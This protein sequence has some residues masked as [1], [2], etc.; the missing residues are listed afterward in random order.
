MI[1]VKI[2]DDG[3][4]MSP[5]EL[6]H[7]TEPFYTTKPAGTGIGLAI[8]K[9]YIEEIGGTITISSEKN[10]Y[11]CV[12]IRLPKRIENEGDRH[13]AERSDH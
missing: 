9:Q 3:V 13:E 10:R 4:G 6:A 7:C 12:E 1:D 11:T 8:S 2:S 5:E